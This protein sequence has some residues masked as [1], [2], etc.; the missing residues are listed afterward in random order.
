MWQNAMYWLEAHLGWIAVA[1]LAV[2]AALVLA[3]CDSRRIEKLEEGVST[4]ADVRAAMGEPEHI[5]PEPGGART[6]EYNRQPKGH[7][8]YMIT[9]GSNGIMT[10]LVQVLTPERFA[11]AVPGLQQEAVRR[12][13][14]RPARVVPYALKGETDWTWHYLENGN[15]S[16]SFTVTFGPDNRLRRTSRTQDESNSVPDPR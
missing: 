8:N 3:G 4:E 7:R 15:Q 6:L 9:V 10:A 12:L 16:Y 13:Y 14:G 5:W 11:L 2:A 1:A